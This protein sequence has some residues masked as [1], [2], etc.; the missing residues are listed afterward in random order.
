MSWL[1]NAAQLDK[2]RKNQ[3]NVIILD[4]S[5]HHSDRDAKQE[6]A[7]KHII[8]AQ[9]FDIDAFSD[10]QSDIPHTL[11]QDE[12]LISEKLSALGI[13]DDSKIIFYDNSELHTACRALWMFKIFGHNTQQ[14]YILDG[15]LMAWERYGGK[16]TSGLPTIT[17]R[18]YSA[19]LQPQFLR[20]LAQMKQHCLNPEEQVIDVRHP[21]RFAGGPEIRPGVRLGHLPGSENFPFFAFFD[22]NNCF[23]PLEKIRKRM[24]DVSID[25]KV[26]TICMCGSGITAPILDFVLDLMGYTQHAVYDG[27]WTEWGKETLYAGESSLAERPVET[28]LGK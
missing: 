8:D 3:R 5:Y 16:T 10:P 18:S 19:R 25:P 7:E 26:P 9:F 24:L 11:I 12:K 4:A 6:F 1:I 14:L 13:R 15:G 28:C 21:V 17:P 27:S 2:F 22:Q 23:L 20:T